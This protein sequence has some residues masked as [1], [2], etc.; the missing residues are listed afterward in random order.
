MGKVKFGMCEWCI[1]TKRYDRFRL[2][3][4]MGYQ[5][6]V[7]DLGNY[8]QSDSLYNK[9]T[10]DRYMR[11]A[12][13]YG[14]AMPTLSVNALCDLGM[15]I[16]DSYDQIVL[17][18]DALVATAIEMDIKLLQIPSFVNG[19]IKDEAG[20]QST[21]KCLQYLCKIT[22]NTDIVVGWESCTDGPSSLRMLEMI[23]EPHLKLYF[24]TANPLWLCGGLDGPQVLDTIRDSVVE[25]HMKEVG[26][27]ESSDKLEF[28]RLG[29]G[30]VGFM[31][32]VEIMKSMDYSGWMHN[33]NELSAP[34]LMQD[35][36]L[37]EELFGK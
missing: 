21:A 20:F 25:F 9:Q 11:M 30:A 31:Q 27:T 17:T 5:G 2:C 13:E 15:A 12:Q 3:R 37:L 22:K 6:M 32:S 4:D 14:I 7:V 10:R 24:D 26:Y 8:E 36:A 29:T 34:L 18:F 35:L 33:E 1:P 23:S 28:M 19:I 16:G